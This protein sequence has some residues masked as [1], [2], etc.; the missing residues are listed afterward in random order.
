MAVSDR[1]SNAVAFAQRQVDRVISPE[2]RQTAYDRTKAFA[3][4]RP[5]LFVCLCLSLPPLL[6]I[7]S[8]RIASLHPYISIH[9]IHE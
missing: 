8:H 5:L 2:T 9:A 6:R 4:A 7:A 1:A 3:A